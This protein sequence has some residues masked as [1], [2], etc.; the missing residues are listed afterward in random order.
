MQASL[1][2]ISSRSENLIFGIA[3]FL[4]RARRESYALKIGP[5]LVL[6]VLACAAKIMAAHF[7]AAGKINRLGSMDLGRH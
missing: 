4:S 6:I 3:L 1:D 7:R 2:E 5:P